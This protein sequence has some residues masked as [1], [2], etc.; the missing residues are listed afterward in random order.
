MEE[1][2]ELQKIKIIRDGSSFID[3]NGILRGYWGGFKESYMVDDYKDEMFGIYYNMYARYVPI[4]EYG[5]FYGIFDCRKYDGVIHIGNNLYISERNN[6]FGLLEGN[7]NVI[8]HTVYLEIKHCHLKDWI[9]LVKTETGVFIYNITKGITTK[10]FEELTINFG[11]RHKEQVYFKENNRYGLINLEGDVILPAKFYH[12]GLQ[13]KIQDIGLSNKFKDNNYGV[14]VE[15]GLLFG[16]IPIDL[17]DNCYRIAKGYSDCFYITEKDGRYGLLT[18]K[19]ETITPPVFDDIILYNP[20]KAC[21]WVANGYHKISFGRKNNNK[22]IYYTIV[23]VIAKKDNLYWL[24]N[25]YNG[26]C[27][28]EGCEYIDYI[29][30]ENEYRNAPYIDYKKGN[31]KGYVLIDGEIINNK[32]YDEIRFNRNNIYVSKSGKHGI[33]EITGGF[34]VPCI[35]DSI[36][37]EGRNKF[38]AFNDGKEDVFDYSKPEVYHNYNEPRRYSKYAGTYAQD[39]M[40]YSDDDIDTIFDG[41]PSA[42]WNID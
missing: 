2:N 19:T 24:Y 36:V 26:Q 18:W 27:I 28:L 25:A 37:N 17:Y 20:R 8:L 41:D 30:N 16:K 22:M 35:Y 31:E 7:N 4:N 23:F 6:R 13:Y 3:I 10:E 38:R 21:R 5:F 1:N 11:D 9:C 33:L 40:G 29:E 15:N 42:Y 34:L 32:D 14:Y 12:L 39:E